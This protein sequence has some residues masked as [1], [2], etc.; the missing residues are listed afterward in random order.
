MKMTTFRN[1]ITTWM[2]RALVATVPLVLA[3]CG[4]GDQLAAGGIVGTGISITSVGSVSALG[5]DVVTVNGIQFTA[6]AA[7]VRVNG[8]AATQ[9]ALKVGLV[10]TIQGQ[11]LPDGTTTAQTIESRAEVKGIVTGVDSAG[12]SFTILGQRVLT[13]QLTVFGG[14]SFATLLNQYVEVSGFRAAPGDVLATRVDISAT[15]TPGATLEVT[16]VVSAFDA[17]AKTFAIGAQVVDFSQVGAAFLSPALANG[18]VAEVRGTMVSAGGRLIAAEIYVVTTTVPGPENSKVEVEGVI[19]NFTGLASFRVN[20]QLV[21]GRGAAVTGGSMAMVVDGAKVE[22]EGTMTQG[23]VVASKIEIEQEAEIVIDATVEAVDPAGI[24]LGGQRFMVTATTQFEDRSAAAVRDFG[25]AAVRVGDRLQVNAVQGA[26]GLAATR[27]VRVDPQAAGGSGATS[28]VEGSITEFASI[29]SFKVAGQTINAS[30][31]KIEGGIA[32]DLAVGRT[33][34]VEGVLAGNILLATRIVLMPADTPPSAAA[35]LEGL[36]TGFVSQANFNVS[37]QSVDATHASFEGG[38]AADLANGRS[39]TVQGVAAGGVF[40]ATK[41]VF[42][43]AT[44]GSTLEVEGLISS[45]ASVANFKVA[46]QQV[47]ATSA[48]IS[49][50]TAADLAN[51]RKVSVVGPVAGGVLKATTVEIQDAPELTEAEVR[52]T[53]TNFVSVG[54]FVV[55]AR[56]IDA[57][58][59]TFEHGTAANLANG[60]QV[61]IAGKLVGNVLVADKVGFE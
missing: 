50:G 57:S 10:V 38:V 20:G 19:T 25:L 30:S 1:S 13:D 11:T 36:I 49:N 21:D 12:R 9:A 24:T 41:V 37:G 54:N 59:A 42:K 58:K 39:V 44:S 22:V 26:A 32:G 48:R 7:S 45:F 33:V 4:G 60:V 43:S 53:I 35:T 27:V 34:A 56:K 23:V 51:G 17:V 61:E 29:A 5:P 31:A 18:V 40:V 47:D 55:A 14:G 46:G 16:G 6:K 52:G 28:E 15:S 2:L 3:A 8:E